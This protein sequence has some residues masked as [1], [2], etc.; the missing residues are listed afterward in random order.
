MTC[1]NCLPA[2]AQVNAPLRVNPMAYQSKERVSRPM[3]PVVAAVVVVAEVAAEV[4]V[5]AAE[6]AVAVA[7]SKSAGAVFDWA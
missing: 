1:K 4:A 3:A 7:G 6:V 2:T 5:V